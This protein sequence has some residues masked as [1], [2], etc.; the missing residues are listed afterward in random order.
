MKKFKFRFVCLKLVTLIALVS[1]DGLIAEMRVV[2]EDNG[3][4]Y[5][6]DGEN[7]YNYKKE[8]I[9]P[10]SRRYSLVKFGPSVTF[11]G[12]FYVYKQTEAGEFKGVC[13]IS[14]KEIIAP[15]YKYLD[16][17]ESEPYFNESWKRSVDFSGKEY[18]SKEGPL[19]FKYGDGFYEDWWSW[20]VKGKKRG[21]FNTK[22]YYRLI[23]LGRQTLR[24]T[25][26]LPENSKKSQCIMTRGFRFKASQNNDKDAFTWIKLNSNGLIGASNLK[27]EIIIPTVYE[28]IEYMDLGDGMG[29]FVCT[30]SSVKK[31][32]TLS[33]RMLF[34]TLGQGKLSFKKDKIGY[35]VYEYFT[36]QGPYVEIFNISGDCIVGFQ[37]KRNREDY[38]GASYCDDAGDLGY[39][40]IYK[41]GKAGAVDIYGNLIVEPRYKIFYYGKRG[42]VGNGKWLGIELR[43]DG[44]AD[45]SQQIKWAQEKQENR[46][47]MLNGLLQSFAI[48]LQTSFAM[49]QNSQYASNIPKAP[50]GSIAAQMEQPGYFNAINNQL[51][52]TS[53]AQAQQQDWNEYE[54]VKRDLHRPD[55]TY[56]EYQVMQGQAIETLKNEGYDIIAEQRKI[57]D[58]LHEAN[59][60]S[61]NSGRENIERIREYNQLKNGTVSTTSIPESTFSLRETT[62]KNEKS[63]STSV[64]T[65]EKSN[66]K[67]TVPNQT[68]DQKLDSKEQFKH[69][70]VSSSDYK[71]IKSIEVY[72]RDGNQ[73]RKMNI[74]AELCKKGAHMYVKIGDIYYLRVSSNWLRFQNAINYGHRQLYYN[75]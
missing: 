49:C 7:I 33:G 31:V 17:Y 44:T 18:C 13:D 4:V 45:N 65:S 50:V 22:E 57:A 69:D 23:D 20:L 21:K 37:N 27:G 75:N 36:N 35:F 48:G 1:P 12:F 71:R 24:A 64:N 52:A 2:V 53:I 15:K 25:R 70:A 26:S 46:Q 5:Y 61:W 11:G 38:E 28:D 14:G 30:D 29:C 54:R 60:A 6:R 51:M 32:F 41:K 47:R 16:L 39:F 66:E 72:Y 8:L 59:R 73:A 74:N 40:E 9:I 10:A 68:H 62:S 63:S 58:D 67:S 3:F 56:G 19:T 55:M 34:Y 42:F 43:S